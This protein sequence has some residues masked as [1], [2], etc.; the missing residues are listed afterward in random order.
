[1]S[2]LAMSRIGVLVTALILLLMTTIRM[3]DA[4]PWM[5]RKLL[6]WSTHCFETDSLRARFEEE[7]LADLEEVP[8][9]LAKL[10]HCLGVLLFT[11][12]PLLARSRWKRSRL[13]RWLNRVTTRLRPTRALANGGCGAVLTR[14]GAI[15]LGLAVTGLM[16]MQSVQFTLRLI[17]PSAAP[18]G[19]SASAGVSQPHAWQFHQVAGVN[20]SGQ[21]AVMA[22]RPMPGGT[23]FLTKVFG[24]PAGTLFRMFII[25]TD[26]KQYLAGTWTTKWPHLVGTGT[27]NSR[28]GA[29]WYSGSTTLIESEIRMLVFKTG[30]APP[31]IITMPH[32]AAPVGGAPYP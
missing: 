13:A 11:A 18:S 22:Y 14:A 4:W 10:V 32:L 8:G 5:S 16:T 30:V 7:W 1:M 3:T 23:M 29:R 19:A 12:A 26:G 2:V 21:E 28:E 9:K 20:N 24:I 6:R 17:H 25:S 31:V 15:A 27:T